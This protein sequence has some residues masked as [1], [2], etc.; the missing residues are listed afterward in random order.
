MARSREQLLNEW[1]YKNSPQWFEAVL[2][3]QDHIIA[4]LVREINRL[5]QFE[6]ADRKRQE[7]LDAAKRAAG[8]STNKS[9]DDVWAACLSAY[10]AQQD[11]KTVR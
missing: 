3:E 6:D 1:N 11:E 4:G 7:W 10:R 5:K 8:F 9:F 2:D